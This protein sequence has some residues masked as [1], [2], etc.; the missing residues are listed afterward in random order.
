MSQQE[1]RTVDLPG[2]VV[3]RV[4]ERLGRTEFD[5]VEEYVTFVMEEVLSRVEDET[6]DDEYEGVD[7]DEVKERL[8][9]LGYL[10]S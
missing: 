8:E 1:P 7:E 10:D 3:E 4:E 2:H 9:S 5:S 6:E